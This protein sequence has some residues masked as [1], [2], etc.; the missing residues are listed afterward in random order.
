MAD[1][2]LKELKKEFAR[3]QNTTLRTAQR[4]AAKNS[5]QWQ[6]FTRI[7]LAASANLVT[8]C[9]DGLGPVRPAPP[10]AIEPPEGGEEISPSLPEALYMERVQW[11]IYRDVYSS[12]R[13]ATARCDDISAISFAAMTVKL[14]P[15]YLK[16]KHARRDW[17]IEN[18]R[19]LP[20]E[21]YQAVRTGFLI[22]LSGLLDNVENE[23]AMLANPS[24]PDFA[25]EKIL[26]WKL[27]RLQPRIQEAIRAFEEAA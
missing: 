17:E 27:S 20:I 9:P 26:E 11:A 18:R 12:W 8:L 23:L 19:L 7:K 25:R 15:V 3:W 6:E 21:E 16:A 14:L 13:M 2:A 1:H 22:P 4:H 5:E 24:D 10:S